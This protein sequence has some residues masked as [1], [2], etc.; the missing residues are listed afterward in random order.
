VG[1]GRVEVPTV[2]LLY[3]QMLQAQ[4]A[5]L[6]RTGGGDSNCRGQDHIRTRAALQTHTSDIHAV[7]G[8]LPGALEP[9][10]ACYKGELRI[11][12]FKPCL[13]QP[14]TGPLPSASLR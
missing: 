5:S 8:Q 12:H 9:S 7:P 3:S 13:S 10:L 1:P 11:N 6:S 4:A 2:Q 14:N